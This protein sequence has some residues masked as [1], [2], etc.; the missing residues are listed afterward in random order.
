MTAEVMADFCLAYNVS[1][2]EYLRLTR[3]ERTAF[4]T[5]AARIVNERK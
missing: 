3:T 4:N 2:S 1:P 5:T